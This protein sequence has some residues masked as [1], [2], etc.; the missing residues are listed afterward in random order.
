MVRKTG[1]L[2]P[3]KPAAHGLK[4]NVFG[5]QCG[6]AETGCGKKSE[7]QIPRGLMPARDDK[8]S[9]VSARLKVVP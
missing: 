5:D 8:I 4:R 7:H 2:A 3:A 6:T 1:A 9:S